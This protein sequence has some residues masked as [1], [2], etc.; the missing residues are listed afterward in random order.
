MLFIVTIRAS[1]SRECISIDATEKIF[2]TEQEQI[3][4]CFR[5][6]EQIYASGFRPTFI[7][8]LWRGGSSVGLVVQECLATLGVETDHIALRTSY[9]GRVQYEQVAAEKSPIR[10]HGKQYL[11]ENLNADD[12]LL[13]VDDVFSSGR[14][15]RAVVD[16]LGQGLKRNMPSDIRIAAL[17]YR[18]QTVVDADKPDFYLTE[19]DKWLVLPY[20][21]S[22]LTK[23]EIAQH[24]PYL[25]PLLSQRS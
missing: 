5:L 25:V 12:R 14:H 17:W 9:Q 11:L 16:Q 7:V 10:V 6:G 3:I 4:D 20:E 15:T 8:G 21:F 19:T 18:T 22:G 23:S 24:K 2:V 1:H 13:I